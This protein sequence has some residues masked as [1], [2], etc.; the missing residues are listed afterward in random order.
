MTTLALTTQRAQAALKYADCGD[1]V[2]A[3]AAGVPV[4]TLREWLSR[5]LAGEVEYS[6]WAQRYSELQATDAAIVIGAAKLDSPLKTAQALGY[7]D[8]EKEPV[9]VAVDS[10]AAILALARDTKA[11]PTERIHARLSAPQETHGRDD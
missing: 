1:R 3:K 5:G 9:A 6:E 4:A 10:S 11:L 8:S 7:L 2:A